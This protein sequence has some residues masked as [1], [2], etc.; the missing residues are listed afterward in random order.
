MVYFQSFQGESDSLM[1]AGRN[2]FLWLFPW[3]GLTSRLVCCPWLSLLQLYSRASSLRYCLFPRI[4]LT[5]NLICYQTMSCITPLLFR[6]HSQITDFSYKTS[7]PAAFL[8]IWSLVIYS[9][10]D[11]K[12]TAWRVA[13]CFTCCSKD[14]C[15]IRSLSWVNLCS[16]LM[17]YWV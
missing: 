4:L 12:C 10:M 11:L 7:P 3:R 16:S 5:L 9:N 1:S 8:F 6:F 15:E 14:V 17:N 13:P 2:L